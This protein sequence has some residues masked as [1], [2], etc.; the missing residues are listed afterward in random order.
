M[1]LI[2]RVRS[3][4]REH[5]LMRPDTRVAAAVSGGSDSMALVHVLAALDHAGELQLAGIVH[6]NHQLRPE[7]EE[8]ERF[9]RDLAVALGRPYV[10]DREDVAARADRDNQSIEHAA[11]AAR[12]AFFARAREALA[13]DVIALG[14]TRD[15]QAETFLL[16]LLRGAGPRGWSGMHPRSGIVVRPLLDCGRAELREWLASRGV[17]Y[18]DDATNNDVDIPRN[19]VRAELM[20]LLAARFNPRIAHVLADEAALARDLWHWME[21]ASAPFLRTAGVL[22]IDALRAAPTALRRL[23]LWRALSA[24]A[25]DRHI[26]F[27]HVAALSRLVDSDGDGRLDMPGHTVQRIG[28]R[29]VLTRERAANARVDFEK[30]LSIPGKADIP[31]VGCVITAGED[32]AGRC[33]A[34]SSP[35]MAVV[36]RDLIRESLVV[37]NRRPGDRFRPVGLHGSKK[38]QDLFV[39]AKVPRGERDAVPVVVDERNRIVWVAGFGIDEAFQVTDSS[40]A[41]LVLRLT[42]S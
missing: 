32:A 20:P 5:G 24:A 42:R 15:D 19:R 33:A 41:V 6:F 13:V 22:E 36:R 23:V 8:D 11:R 14:H 27:D 16:R 2:R 12:H 31:E 34:V 10:A 40:Q 4:I 17:A 18:R 21:E 38:L 9:V 1:D 25:A 26:S 35:A 37:R 39:D 29:I 28:A 3:F 30:R 7:A